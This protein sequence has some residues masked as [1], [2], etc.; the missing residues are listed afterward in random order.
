MS[1]AAAGLDHHVAV[2]LEDNVVV[3]VV[4]EDRDGAE[5]GGGTTG[6]GH[7]V[8]LQQVDLRKVRG[9]TLCSLFTL[10][11]KPDYRSALSVLNSIYKPIAVG[12]C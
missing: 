12:R 1:Q 11:H 3:V 7:F 8:W 6:F 2:F 10:G 4:E 5:L 9:V